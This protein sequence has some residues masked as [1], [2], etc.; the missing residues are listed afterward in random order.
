MAGHLFQNGN[1]VPTNSN[2]ADDPSR[3]RVPDPLKGWKHPE[4]QAVVDLLAETVVN[5][6]AKSLAMLAGTDYDPRL[7]SPGADY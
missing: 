3:L 7:V 4:E 1:H 2:P 6:R 5:L